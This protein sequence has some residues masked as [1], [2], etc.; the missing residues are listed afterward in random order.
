MLNIFGALIALGV[1]VTV[2]EAGHFIAARFFG[3]EIEKFS[4]GFGKK[5]FSFRKGDTE[6]RISLIPLG[7]YVKMKGENPDE[8]IVDVEHSYRSKTWWQRAIIA[9]AGPFMNFVLALLLFIFSFGIGRNF[10]DLE[11]VVGSVSEP[12]STY[13]QTGD[14]ILAVNENE[15]IGWNQIAQFASS[16]NDNDFT[17]L[18]KTDRIEVDGIPFDISDWYNIVKPH[19][20]AIVGE[21]SPGMPAYKAGLMTNDIILEVDNEPI[22]DWYEM[23]ELITQNPDNEVKLLIKRNGKTFEKILQLETNIYDDNKI[24]GI[25]QKLPVKIHE[26]FSFL[27]AIE[28]GSLT[29]V[30]FVYLNYAMLLKLIANPAAIKSN[31]GGPVMMYTMSKQTAGKGLDVVLNF[32]G[33]ISLILMIMNLLPIPILDGGHI[34]FCF[35]EGIFRRPLSLKLQIVLQNVGLFL[36]MFLMVFAFWNDINRIFS[37]NA[38][39]NQ[40]KIEMEN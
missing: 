28:Y 13:F 40:Q 5:L 31:I 37:R 24:I 38:S 29:T 36:L 1:L 20:N 23:R 19:V 33:M 17:V 10:E 16:E 6:Y 34:F 25:T 26:K 8:E 4:I 12:Y 9:F 11:P 35:M 32:I 30:N 21:V 27:E 7:G 14:K 15:V 22:D 3:V 2:H 39:I 18:R